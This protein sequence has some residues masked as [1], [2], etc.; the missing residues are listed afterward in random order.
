MNL[1]KMDKLLKNLLNLNKIKLISKANLRKKWKKGKS[2]LMGIKLRSVIHKVNCN[3]VKLEKVQIN[4]IAF[5]HQKV[6]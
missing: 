5:T 3:T 4:F 1:L 2:L 6:L